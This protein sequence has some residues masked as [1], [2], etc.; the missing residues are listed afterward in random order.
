MKR[1]ALSVGGPQNATLKHH[2]GEI[3]P[4]ISP[5]FLRRLGRLVPGS[6]WSA[7]SNCSTTPRSTGV[8]KR[9]ANAMR[10]PAS[11]RR[12]TS[13]PI[14]C[15]RVTP[16]SAVRPLEARLKRRSALVSST[17]A[18][19]RPA[20]R[21]S[22]TTRFTSRDVA[23]AGRGHASARI[24][25]EASSASDRPSA[26]RLHVGCQQGYADDRRVS[27]RAAMHAAHPLRAG[28]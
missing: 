4:Q 5:T 26:L 3:H 10:R 15:W 27:R 21:A 13:T 6:S 25:E 8:R 9:S 28:G 16:T 12:S 14:A 2:L 23:D 19:G 17:V 1:I 20:T 18:T 22:A 24:M 7:P 11:G